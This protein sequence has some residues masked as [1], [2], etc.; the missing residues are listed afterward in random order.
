M[1]NP[2]C[3]FLLPVA[4]T[5][6]L[7]A[8]PGTAQADEW[9]KTYTVSGKATVHVETNDGG[10]RVSTWD[11]KQIQVRIET[12][13]WKINDSEVRIMDRQTGDRL[14]L[15][16]RVPNVNFSFGNNR[17]SLSI[18]LRVPREADLNIRSG[19]GSVETANNI[20]VVDI[21]TG[22]GHINVSRVKGDIRL[23]TGDGH[24]EATSLDG[25]LDASTGDGRIH[26]EGRFDSLNLKTNDGAIDA[27][28]LRDSRIQNSWM[29]RTGDGDVTLRLPENFQADLDLQTGDGSINLEF[30][31]ATSGKISRS[32]LHGKLNGGGL[33]LMARTGDGSIHILKF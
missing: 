9:V 31:V 27:S 23:S 7:L 18:E 1:R 30:P 33:S 19:D 5:G 20:G 22:D 28:V 14:D 4:L 11:G 12:V 32:E 26:V 10:V 16:A 3:A 17:R 8:A 6:V 21:H 29:V 2:A 24:I 25:R 13:G 15:E